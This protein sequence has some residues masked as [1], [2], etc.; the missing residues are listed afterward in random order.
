MM[1]ARRIKME[2]KYQYF[3][4]ILY[5]VGTYHLIQLRKKFFL[6]RNVFVKTKEMQRTQ[7]KDILTNDVLPLHISPENTYR[8]TLI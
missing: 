3:L 2:R 5:N 4:N 8:N 7:T 6:S 1:M